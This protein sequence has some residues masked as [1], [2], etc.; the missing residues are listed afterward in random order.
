MA[1][2]EQMGRENAVRP[3]LRFYQGHAGWHGGQ[4]ASEINKGVWR[5]VPG[6]ANWVFMAELDALWEEVLNPLEKKIE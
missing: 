4:L 3:R 6:S 2:I 5:L 1:A